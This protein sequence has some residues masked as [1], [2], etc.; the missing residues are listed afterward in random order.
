MKKTWYKIILGIIKKMFIVYELAWLM[1]L[2]M[3]NVYS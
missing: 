1:L 3:Q 2:T